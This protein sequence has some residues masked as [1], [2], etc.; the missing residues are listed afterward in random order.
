MS[1]PKL[2]DCRVLLSDALDRWCQDCLIAEIMALRDRLALHAQLDSAELSLLPM[3]YL[4]RLVDAPKE[5][6]H[7]DL[8]PHATCGAPLSCDCGCPVCW[9][10]KAGIIRAGAEAIHRSY[11]AR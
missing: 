6:V 3:L 10:A 9:Q 7:D 11:T 2:L 1:C 8:E 5:A 4:Q